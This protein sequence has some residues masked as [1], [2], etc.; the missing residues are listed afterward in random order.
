M[1][2][3]VFAECDIVKLIGDSRDFTVPARFRTSYWLW[4]QENNIKTE[5]QGSLNG[6]DLWRV[7]NDEHRML[8]VLRWS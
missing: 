1:T 3:K 5:F 4:C 6:V 2:I 8:A 7:K